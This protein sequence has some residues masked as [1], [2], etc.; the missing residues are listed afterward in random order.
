ME[1]QEKEAQKGSNFLGGSFSNRDYVIALIQF[2]RESKP[3][4]LKI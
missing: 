4:Y 1:L 3:E 2:R